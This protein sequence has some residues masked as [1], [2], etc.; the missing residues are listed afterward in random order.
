MIIR[1]TPSDIEKFVMVD[2]EL[3]FKLQQKGFV[4]TYMDNDVLYF[5]K[6]NKILKALEKL[7]NEF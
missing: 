2:G 6:T 1:D 7:N 5:K 4:P 3:A